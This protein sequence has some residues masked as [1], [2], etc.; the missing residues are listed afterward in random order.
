[1]KNAQG[2]QNK[3]LMVIFALISGNPFKKI[4]CA[5]CTLYTSFTLLRV[6]ETLNSKS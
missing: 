4:V 5:V 3:I 2:K 6:V 1:M